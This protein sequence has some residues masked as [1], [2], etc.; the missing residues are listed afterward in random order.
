MKKAATLGAKNSQ[1]EEVGQI[2]SAL[3][4]AQATVEVALTSRKKK[5]KGRMIGTDI[6]T[7]LVEVDTCAGI[8]KLAKDALCQVN[9][10]TPAMKC[11]FATSIKNYESLGTYSNLIRLVL[12]APT[13]I[14]HEQ[15][16]DV[17][18][19]PCGPDS[20]LSVKVRIDNAIHICTPLDVSFAGIR[21]SL[22]PDDDPGFTV[23][24]EIDA[25]TSFCG[26][27][28]LD[29]KAVVQWVEDHTYGVLIPGFMLDGEFHPPAQWMEVLHG[30][31]VKWS[32]S[33][34][35]VA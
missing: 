13:T 35:S 14:S 32:I 34:P 6:R 20:G 29:F 30:L 2:L 22:S 9:C 26:W 31:Q 21:F 24:Q 7:L 19:I 3:S 28:R 33:R 4:A 10:T 23:G 5:F 1:R 12:I 16:R 11:Q 25:M 27:Y 17:F 8:G 18:R 15:N